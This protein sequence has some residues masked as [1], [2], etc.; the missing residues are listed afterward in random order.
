MVFRK[1]KPFPAEADVPKGV[2]ILLAL[3]LIQIS[4]GSRGSAWRRLAFSGV[5]AGAGLTEIL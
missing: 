1:S 5:F 2:R 3:F 4:G